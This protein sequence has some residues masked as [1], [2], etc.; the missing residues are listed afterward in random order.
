MRLERERNRACD[1]CGVLDVSLVIVGGKY[2]PKQ[3]RLCGVCVDRLQ[4]LRVQMFQG[5]LDAVETWGGP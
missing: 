2:N 3:M 1:D 5:G 4:R